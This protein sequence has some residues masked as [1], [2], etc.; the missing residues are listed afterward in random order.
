M[1][2]HMRV[3][4]T[5][6]A[7]IGA[8]LPSAA[9]PTIVISSGNNTPSTIAEHRALAAASV[10]ARHVVASRSSHWVQFDEPELIV[11]AIKELIDRA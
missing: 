10:T 3:L 1:A 9:I 8:L 6:G 4:E 5:E 2:A 11:A 7:A